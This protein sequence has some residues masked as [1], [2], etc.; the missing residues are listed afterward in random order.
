MRR[1]TAIGGFP[2]PF[3]PQTKLQAPLLHPALAPDEHSFLPTRA[4]AR[5]TVIRQIGLVMQLGTDAVPDKLAHYRKTVLLDQTLHRMAHITEAVACAHLFDGAVERVA[6]YIQQ[7]LQFRFYVA[8][9][10]RYRRIREVPVHFHAEV[11]GDDVAFSQ[12]ALR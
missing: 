11:D 5:F 1:R 2:N 12:L 3:V 7:L 9:R 10:N 4:P 8:D 6:S